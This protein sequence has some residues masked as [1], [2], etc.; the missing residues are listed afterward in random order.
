MDAS[1][2][3]HGGRLLAAPHT[4]RGAAGMALLAAISVIGVAGASARKN[5]KSK[6]KDGRCAVIRCRSCHICKKGACRPHFNGEPCGS[7]G[8]CLDGECIAEAGCWRAGG[9]GRDPSIDGRPPSP[10]LRLD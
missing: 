6:R 10:G 5:E 4:R 3:G 2:L 1:R 8:V 9:R 7:A